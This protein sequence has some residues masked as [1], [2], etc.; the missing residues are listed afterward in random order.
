MDLNLD[1][2]LHIL[3]EM[4]FISLVALSEANK[5]FSNLVRDILK[6]KL[7]N[8]LVI[9]TAPS[10]TS[11][12]NQTESLSIGTRYVRET[13]DCIRIKQFTI[14]AKVLQSVGSLI[15]NVRV[16]ALPN[17]ATKSIFR[18]VNL[19]CSKTLSQFEIR[20][21]FD[22]ILDEFIKPFEKVDKVTL[23]G[24]FENMHE[25]DLRF[26]EIFP[27]ICVSS[28]SKELAFKK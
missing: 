14:G 11:E 19:Y 17:N 18:L 27:Q 2:Q 1:C 7:A 21:A 20:S 6:R 13:D 23:R 22:N 4:D 24:N 12:K 26:D 25:S 9:F 3:N 28:V 10:I 16:D 8:K 5:H 15:S